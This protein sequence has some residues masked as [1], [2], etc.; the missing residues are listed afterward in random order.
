MITARRS[1]VFTVT[2]RARGGVD[3][4]ERNPA[5]YA[6][7]EPSRTESP[8]EARLRRRRNLDRLLNYD[9]APETDQDEQAA[10][11]EETAAAEQPATAA[12]SDD[13]IR[14]T[15]TTTQFIDGD[16]QIFNDA[17]KSKEERKS[18][19]RLN[20]KGKL[21]VV[22]YALAVTVILALIVLNT[23][24][25]KSLSKEVSALERTYTAKVQ[26]IAAQNAEIAEISSPE[27]VIPIA[28]DLG[29]VLR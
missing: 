9:R 18:T 24:V 4:L 12:Y 27:H 7:S 29:M 13:D 19:Y 3:L 23:G 6:E 26:A 8:E 22:L 1:D 20:G 15:T 17:A 5:G 28:R 21:V 16:P 2:D 11:A 14:P 10:V 25:L